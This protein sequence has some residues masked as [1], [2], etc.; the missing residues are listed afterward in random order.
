M[1]W[2][3]GQHVYYLPVDPCEWELYVKPREWV[4]PMAIVVD[5]EEIG[6]Q[7]ALAR[8]PYVLH[9]LV[10][11]GGEST[12]SCSHCPSRWVYR[13]R[14]HV[15]CLLRRALIQE[16]LMFSE[17]K[18]DCLACTDWGAWGCLL[19]FWICS[20][21]IGCPRFWLFHRTGSWWLKRLR[22]LSGSLGR[23]VVGLESPL[24]F[25]SSIS[26]CLSLWW[27]RCQIQIWSRSS[28]WNWA[29]ILFCRY[30]SYTG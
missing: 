21:R 15:Y 14:W 10:I 9:I 1:A 3:F 16:Y 20:R 12:W 29:R 23:L 25:D 5:S 6:K 30:L 11:F 28:T 24:E 17:V 22:I 13:V 8:H 4:V 19:Q 7:V 26:R 27:W 18:A 2:R